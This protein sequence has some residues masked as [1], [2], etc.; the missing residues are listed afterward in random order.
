MIRQLKMFSLTAILLI[1]LACG[2]SEREDIA[3]ASKNL[4]DLVDFN[5]HIKPI[6]SD[7]C[8]AC[9]GPDDKAREGNLRLDKVT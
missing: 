1:S 8:Y 4:P 2:R 5:F 6:L 3:I 7:R 9:H